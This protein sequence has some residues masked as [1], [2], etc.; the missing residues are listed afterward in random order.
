MSTAPRWEP[1]DSDTADLLSLVADT[2]HPSADYEWRV[3]NTCLAAARDGDIIRPNVLR[4]LLRNRVAPRRIGAYTHR[5][6]R[7]GLIAYTGEYE[8]SDDRQGGNAGRPMRVMRWLNK[9][10]AS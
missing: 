9:E 4:P 1:V 2:N 10:N 8:V 3:F 7:E 5:A 6:L